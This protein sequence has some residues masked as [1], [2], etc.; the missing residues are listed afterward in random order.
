VAMLVMAVSGVAV[1][2]QRSSVGSNPIVAAPPSFTNYPRLKTQTVGDRNYENRMA[3][4]GPGRIRSGGS[5][6]D[7]TM[8][9]WA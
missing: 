6:G 5:D 9:R 1:P 4:P 3:L 8:E 2:A 7:R